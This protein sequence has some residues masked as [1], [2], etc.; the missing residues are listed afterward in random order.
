MKNLKYKEELTNTVLKLIEPHKGILAADE[1]LGTIGKRFKMINIENNH[2]NR[3]NYRKLLF[4]T[5]DIE[6]YLSGVITFEETL[7]DNKLIQPLLDKNIIIGIK[8]DRGL[9][10]IPLSEEK[11]T[12][13]LDDLRERCHKYYNTGARFAKWRCVFD[14]DQKNN[15]PSDNA[16]KTNAYILAKYAAM[17]LE[18]G[19]V[20]LVEPEVLINDCDNINYVANVTAMVI[21]QV[22]KELK[23]QNVDISLTLLKPNMIRNYTPNENYTKKELN[24]IAQHTLRVLSHFVPKKVKGIFFLSGGMTEKDAQIALFKINQLKNKQKKFKHMCHLSFSYGRA[25]QHSVLH[26]WEGKEE[27][28]QSAQNELLGRARLNSES[29]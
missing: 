25:L 24:N 16:I 1:S 20:P 13:G 21:D 23:L 15:L 28:I 5:P 27:N 26:I 4:T 12:K 29:C 6:Q 10:K 8:T 3:F 7:F 22:Y 18:T 11:M 2:E 14:I 19:L 17:S 9:M